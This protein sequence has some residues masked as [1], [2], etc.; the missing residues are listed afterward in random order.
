MQALLEKGIRVKL[1][2]LMEG[3]NMVIIGYIKN[4][5]YEEYCA[6][7]ITMR[8]QGYGHAETIDSMQALV[9]P[10]FAKPPLRSL[11]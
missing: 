1:M 6:L 10:N 7:Y 2:T 9:D 3:L 5:K 11:S 4:Q 8:D